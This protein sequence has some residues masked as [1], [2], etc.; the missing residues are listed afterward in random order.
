MQHATAVLPS[1]P[2]HLADIFDRVERVN[3]I[4]NDLS[5]VQAFVASAVDG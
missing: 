2:A 4:D 1:L 3:L 5:D